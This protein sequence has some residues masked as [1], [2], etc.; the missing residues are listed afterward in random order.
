MPCNAVLR[1]AMKY[2]HLCN[3]GQRRYTS[4]YTEHVT[5]NQRVQGSSPCAPTKL[6][7]GLAE[8]GRAFCRFGDAWAVGRFC[9]T[10]RDISATMNGRFRRQSCR[11]ACHVRRRLS[12]AR[13]ARS[14]GRIPRR[15]GRRHRGDL[16]DYG[17]L[18]SRLHRDA[19]GGWVAYAQ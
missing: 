13:K 5:L 17:S 16:S 9:C 15:L 7:K 4:K 8:N 19:E 2:N 6:F 14:R 11:D 12:L 18:G 10:A 1:S 3:T